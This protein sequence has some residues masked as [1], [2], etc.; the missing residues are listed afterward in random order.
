MPFV[1]SREYDEGIF[2]LLTTKEL[3]TTVYHAP[4]CFVI[5]KFTC[6]RTDKVVKYFL[7]PTRNNN[8]LASAD[9]S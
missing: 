7:V 2:F 5:Q 4:C 8:K 9:D 1:M 6:D 3:S